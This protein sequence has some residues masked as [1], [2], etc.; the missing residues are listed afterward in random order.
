MD[1]NTVALTGRLTKDPETKKI[2]DND[3]CTFRL[4]SSQVFGKEEKSLFI[5]VEIWGNQAVS[6]GKFLAKG[7]LVGVSGQLAY[8]SWKNKEGETNSKVY[9]KAQ[10]VSFLGE[11]KTTAG[12]PEAKGESSTSIPVAAPK[13]KDVSSKSVDESD[14]LPF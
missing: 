3:L 13:K 14:D 11:K 1:I 7:S 9:V 4:A 8:D 10:N 6:C 2:K 5:D 12:T